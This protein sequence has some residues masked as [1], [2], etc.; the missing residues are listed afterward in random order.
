[1]GWNSYDSYGG[2][3]NE[4]EF[5][6]NAAFVAKHLA[7]YGWKYVVIDYYWYLPNP[8]PAEGK[9]SGADAVMDAY[10]RLLPVPSRFPSSANRQGFKPLADYVHSLGLKFGIHIMRGIPRAAVEK[11]LP[12]LGTKAHARDVADLQNTCS[13][14][15]VMHGVDVSKPAGQAYYDSIARLYASWGVDYIKADDMSRAQDPKG[16]TYHGPE[17]EA[18]RKAMNKTGRPMVLSLSP[19]PTQLVNAASVTRWSQLWRISNDV[20]DNWKAVRQQF[21]YCR[22]W[23]H[24]SKPGHWPD[25][26]MLPLGRLCVRGF[27][28]APRPSR[29]THDEQITLMT[30]WA[31]FRSPLMMDGDLPTSDPFTLSLLTNPEVIAVDQASTGEHELFRDGNKIAW[32]SSTADG[33][34]RYIALF[35]IGD[36]PA[37]VNVS[38]EQNGLRTK[39]Y[40][41]LDLWKHKNLGEFEGNFSVELNP[42]AAGLY[43]L[44]PAVGMPGGK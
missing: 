16:E 32:I 8:S 21:D 4:A 10:G 28:D 43:K 14:S 33:L 24:Y 34:D 41:A 17:I 5:K 11:N 37:Q 35:N 19:G 7:R 27:K 39:Y 31:I 20:W 15:N 13:W 36:Q 3:V 12:I 22:D 18:L 44:T 1:M 40:I 23:E 38:K 9:A 30:L 25:A 42:H 6:A 29:L 2:D 26:D